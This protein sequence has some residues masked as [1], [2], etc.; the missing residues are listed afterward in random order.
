MEAR[1]AHV[2]LYGGHHRLWPVVLQVPW[3]AGDV[4]LVDGRVESSLYLLIG[5]DDKRIFEC[6]LAASCRKFYLGDRFG[7]TAYHL[8]F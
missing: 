7:D 3:C 4:D 2:D 5:L 6:G 8:R 1:S